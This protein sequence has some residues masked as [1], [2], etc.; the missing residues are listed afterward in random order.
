M[1]EPAPVV[2]KAQPIVATAGLSRPRLHLVPGLVEPT[3]SPAFETEREEAEWLIRE[4][5]FRL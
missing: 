5:G 4:C 3:A 1:S 2:L